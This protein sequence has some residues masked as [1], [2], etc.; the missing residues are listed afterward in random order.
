[1]AVMALTRGAAANHLYYKAS[2][3]VDFVDQGIPDQ[4]Q[5]VNTRPSVVEYQG[6]VYVF[7]MF[8]TPLV[9]TEARSNHVAGVPAP[10]RGP[11]LS[12]GTSSGG[13][14]GLAIGYL[15]YVHKEGGKVVQEGNPST[16]SATLELNGEGRVWSNLPDSPV[17]PRVTHLRGYLSMDGGIPAFAWER[18]L[19]VTTVTENLPTLSLGTRL[20]VFEGLDGEFDADIYARGV[21]PN[22][23][24][25]EIYH[26]AH[27]V[28]GDYNFP[29]RV[30]FSRLFEP[31]SFNRVVK[32]RGWIDTLDGEAVTGLKRWGDIL[33]VGYLGGAY[34]IQGFSSRD[35]QIV[36][37]SNYYGVLSH[38]ALQLAG[39][40]SDLFGAGQEGPW[41]Y[42]GAFHDLMNDSLHRFWRDD[43]RASQGIYEACFAAEDRYTKTYQLVI[44]RAASPR[45]FKYIGHI[46]PLRK[47]EAEPWWTIDIRAREDSSIGSIVISDSNHY[48][49]LLSGSCDGFIRRENVEDDADDDG[50]AF[51]KAMRVTTKHFFFGDQSGDEA[52]GRNYNSLDV[53]LK[54]ENNA[55]T[56]GLY[57]GDDSANEAATPQKT[58][59]IP[60]GTITAPFA[61]VPRT[62]I[63]F[64][65]LAEVNGK[66]LTLDFNVSAPVGVALRGFGIYHSLGHQERLRS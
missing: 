12:L 51:M 9:I 64:A 59:T 38:H 23:R 47:G 7:G 42:D 19:G 14:S 32:E 15:T 46:E 29:G 22:G 4:T 1:M 61:K 6:R 21:P 48:R 63:Y 56:V 57:G 27:W 5:N 50:D 26:D 62:S 54:N 24:F 33:V 17:N 8:T 13:S 2:S 41:R 25:N 10:E 39:P 3:T 66:G 37:I 44:P 49:E 36:K 45:T 34:A 31:E 52:H 53:F 11:T 30:Y 20:P 40:N 58:L 65:P 16:P 43:Y 18:T 35:Y 28:S 60:V 55:V